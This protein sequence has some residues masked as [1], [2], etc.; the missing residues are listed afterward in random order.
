VTLLTKYVNNGTGGK[1]L[2]QATHGDLASPLYQSDFWIPA[3]L[4]GLGL[5]FT[6]ISAGTRSRLAMI[7][8]AVASIGLIG[9]TLHIPSKG[10]SPGFHPYGSSYWLSLGAAVVMVIGAAVALAARRRAP[11]PRSSPRGTRHDPVR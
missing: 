4:A 3:G 6:A 11:D 9:Y 10:A 2:W 1:S 5:L 7:G 8:T